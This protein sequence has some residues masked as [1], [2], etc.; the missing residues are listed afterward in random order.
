MNGVLDALALAHEQGIVHRDLKPSN[1]LLGR[2]G[3]ARVMDFGIAARTGDAA[4]D[5][6]VGT[7]NYI[8][9]EAAR[10]EAPHPAMDVFSAGLMLAEMLCGRRL[11]DERD[12][13]RALARVQ[14]EDLVLPA[15]AAVDEIGRAH[16]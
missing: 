7:P 10:G 15:L 8:S 13:Y 3:R 9:P 6:I 1:I 12:I 16:V 2:D 11:L 5:L 4:Q 14:A